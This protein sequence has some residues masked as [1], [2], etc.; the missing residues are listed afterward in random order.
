MSIFYGNR[1]G[2]IKQMAAGLGTA[3]GTYQS[4]I[5]AVGSGDFLMHKQ[6]Q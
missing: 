1:Q 3:L 6:Q 4:K 5:K 2:I